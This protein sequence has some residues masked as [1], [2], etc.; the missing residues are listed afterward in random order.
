MAQEHLEQMIRLAEEFFKTK[1]D[2]D[3][4]TVDRR[5]RARL[6]KIHPA[7]LSERRTSKGP[8]AW[9]LVFPT[10]RDLMNAFLTKKIGE[11]QLVYRTP[12]HRSYEAIYL[13]SALVLSEYRGKGYAKLL[14]C[15]AISAI[16]KTHPITCLFC[17]PFS[18]EGRRLAKYVAQESNLPLHIRKK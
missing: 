16:R 6:I 9:V 4:I 10:T 14:T 18:K 8:I 2:P 13:C 1:N 17:W 11:R 5:T 15:K 12:L 7:S 3:Q